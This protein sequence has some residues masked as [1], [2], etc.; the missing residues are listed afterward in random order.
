M[1]LGHKMVS[2]AL[3]FLRYTEQINEV[4]LVVINRSRN[5][6]KEKLFLPHS[7]LYQGLRLKDLLFPAQTVEIQ[8]GG[9]IELKMLARSAAVFVPD[10]TAFV[11]YDFYK[12]RSL[13]A[14]A[15]RN[16]PHNEL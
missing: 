11:N 1:M 10:D 7:H 4:A 14:G 12:S 9:N 8:T 5:P 3:V 16:V 2:D 6:L 15:S 13:T